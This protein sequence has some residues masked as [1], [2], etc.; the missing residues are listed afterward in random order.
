[1]ATEK[2]KGKRNTILLIGLG[3]IAFIFCMVL[4]GEGVNLLVN[5]SKPFLGIVCSLLG[6]TGLYFGLN[7]LPSILETTVRQRY[8]ADEAK[9]YL[10]A[11]Y[12]DKTNDDVKILKHD[13]IYPRSDDPD[14]RWRNV[15]YT[16][17]NILEEHDLKETVCNTKV[18]ELDEDCYI[19][20][21]NLCR[22]DII[23]VDINDDQEVS[24]AFER[25]EKGDKDFLRLPPTPENG[26]YNGSFYTLHSRSNDGGGNGL[27]SLTEDPELKKLLES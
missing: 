7:Y 13:T 14:K 23:F 2:Q 24:E 6:G 27:G 19:N 10:R 12:L 1:M 15:M 25:V 3:P 11:T 8:S 4:I 20:K 17:N 5:E 9:A 26:M 21:I 18:I 22:F 16:L